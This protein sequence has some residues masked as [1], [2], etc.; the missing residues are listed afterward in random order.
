[1]V[2]AL[3]SIDPVTAEAGTTAS[4]A[5]T[6]TD[7]VAG[8]SLHLAAVDGTV[9]KGKTSYGSATA[10]TLAVE[11]PKIGKG[12]PARTYSVIL[13]RAGAPT[14]SLA[15]AL[16]VTGPIA[17]NPTVPPVTDPANQVIATKQDAQVGDGVLDGDVF[18]VAQSEADDDDQVLLATTGSFNLP[19]AAADTFVRHEKVRWDDT[20]GQVT[21]EVGSPAFPV[22]GTAGE[23]KAAGVGTVLVRLYGMTL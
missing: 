14:K 1:M 6:G 23:D 9:L 16:E 7:F 3:T 11:V 13:T 12:W 2:L 22:I 19:R 8:D 21:T 18:G 20:E 15:D 4:I 17:V 10:L 5:V